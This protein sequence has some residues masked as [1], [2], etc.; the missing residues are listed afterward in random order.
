MALNSFGSGNWIDRQV[1]GS[2][3]NALLEDLKNY[4]DR[5]LI[6][7]SVC[8]AIQDTLSTVELE[9]NQYTRQSSYGDLHIKW[10]NLRRTYISWNSIGYQTDRVS[11]DIAV[12]NSNQRDELIRQLKKLRGSIKR[13][14][15][16]IIN[17][18][19]NFDRSLAVKQLSILRDFSRLSIDLPDGNRVTI[20]QILP[21]FYQSV[22]NASRDIF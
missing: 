9:I 1:R 18:Y 13:G 15:S 11:G 2:I 6:S 16:K 20:Q 12:N 10:V 21:N 22:T 4:K 17:N 7:Q 3:L 14:S 8:Q 5:G 19:G